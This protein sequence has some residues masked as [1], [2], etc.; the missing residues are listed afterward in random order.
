MIGSSLAEGTMRSF[1]LILAV[2]VL[3]VSAYSVPAA[4]C[5]GAADCRACKNCKSCKHCKVGGACGVCKPP[6]T[7]P[8]KN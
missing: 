2:T 5:T 4:T 3:C 6:T 7:S 8:A 1:R